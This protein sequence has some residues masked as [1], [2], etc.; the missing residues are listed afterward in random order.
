MESREEDKKQIGNGKILKT[1]RIVVAYMNSI[2]NKGKAELEKAVGQTSKL[3]DKLI[4]PNRTLGWKLKAMAGME[5]QN[6][7]SLWE[8]SRV[9]KETLASVVVGVLVRQLGAVIGRSGDLM[10]VWLEKETYKILA[11]N[12]P[13]IKPL[14]RKAIRRK[15]R[16][17][18][19]EIK[20]GKRYLKYRGQ[21]KVTG[22]IFDMIG[23]KEAE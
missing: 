20:N 22:F 7:E 4:E 8:V 1:V 13:M 5:D 17:E 18:K 3:L 11:S 2:N 14:G 21:A 6:H 12:A 15:L 23:A 16:E 9:P 19:K 10:N